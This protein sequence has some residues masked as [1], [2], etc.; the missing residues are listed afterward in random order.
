MYQ[1]HCNEF[2]ENLRQQDKK[3]KLIPDSLVDCNLA[4]SCEI[5]RCFSK[6]PDF[7]SIA[8]VLPSLMECH[9]RRSASDME[10]QTFHNLFLERKI[11][12][13]ASK[14]LLKKGLWDQCCL[15]LPWV[16]ANQRPF[17]LSLQNLFVALSV[18]FGPY[19]DLN[20]D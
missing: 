16:E 15:P 6:C 14:S 3:V 2:R 17:V 18:C 20:G 7:E 5:V 1:C 19:I 13:L 10:A 12:F 9:F 11:E 4:E 8:M